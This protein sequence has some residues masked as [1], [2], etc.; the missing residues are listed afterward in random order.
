MGKALYGHL[1]RPAI[2]AH[3]VAEV[4]RLRAR[5]RE[6]EADNARLRAAVATLTPF[7]AEELP[8]APDDIAD[9][10]DLAAPSA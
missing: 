7:P 8:A 5:L 9:L 2:E 6:V 1:A 10:V 3:L 4:A